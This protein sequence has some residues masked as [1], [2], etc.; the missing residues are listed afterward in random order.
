MSSVFSASVARTNCVLQL[1]P[2]RPFTI[3]AISRLTG[4]KWVVVQSALDTLEKRGIATTRVLNDEVVW[5]PSGEAV[6]AVAHHAALVDLPWSEAL[7]EAGLTSK[8]QAVFVHGSAARNQ[9]T[10]TSDLDVLVVGSASAASL[11]IAFDRVERMVGRPVDVAA[12]SSDE[13]LDGSGRA[14]AA[15]VILRAAIRVYGEW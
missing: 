10:D 2:A 4:D 8:V 12:Y 13:L 3:S 5:E 11:A 6:A 7:D 1:N 15:N 9:M 14:E